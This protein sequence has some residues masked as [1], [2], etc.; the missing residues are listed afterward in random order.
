ML[1]LPLVAALALP[2]SGPRLQ[3]TGQA[4]GG[5]QN[6][7]H[8]SGPWTVYVDGPTEHVAAWDQRSGTVTSTG[9]P[10]DLNAGGGPP[11]GATW[12]LAVRGSFALFLVPEVDAGQDLNGDG[13]QDDEV[14]HVLDL[15]SGVTHGTGLVATVI[16]TVAFGPSAQQGDL[17][18]LAVPESENG[19][20]NGDGDTFD[21]AAFVFDGATGTL[22]DLGLAWAFG[23][24]LEVDGDDVLVAVDEASQGGQDLNGDGDAVDLVL[25]RHDHPT[26]TTTNLGLAGFGIGTAGTSRLFVV[27]ESL[28]GVDLTGDGLT[29]SWA[30]HALDRAGGRPEPLGLA[31]RDFEVVRSARGFEAL[32]IREDDVG[33]GVDVDGD[34]DLLDRH[35]YLWRPAEGRVV[36]TGLPLVTL[37]EARRDGDRAVVTFLGREALDGI[38]VNGDGDL[39]DRVVGSWREGVGFTLAP[40]VTGFP[41]PGQLDGPLVALEVNESQQGADLDGDGSIG[42]TVA[43]G[44]DFAA[45]ASH[46][47]SWKTS[48]PLVA[49]PWLYALRPESDEQVDWSGDGDLLDSVL[50]AVDVATGTETN[51][52]LPVLPGPL[53]FGEVDGASLAVRVDEDGTDLNGDG[54]AFGVVLYVVTP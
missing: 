32:G 43:V 46:V 27:D 53:L 44:H 36:R 7:L 34:G 51:L 1:F 10:V 13:V 47:L 3:N 29:V 14:L 54:F 48:G 25:F 39:Q 22:R 42:G 50:F 45:G 2:G 26:D 20:R 28:E 17:L 11:G 5:F 41:L 38:D 24:N 33:A 9:L 8:Q 52:G 49:G 40:F 35:L 12:D 19:D 18:A 16:G 23:T 15:R 37:L 21:F 4:P 6:A 30:L 31:F